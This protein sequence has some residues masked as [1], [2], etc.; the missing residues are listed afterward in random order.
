MNNKNIRFI[1]LDCKF[2]VQPESNQELPI[3]EI[4]RQMPISTRG[5]K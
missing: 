3:K 1:D 5:V 4:N 2:L